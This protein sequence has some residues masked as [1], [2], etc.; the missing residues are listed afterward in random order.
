MEELILIDREANVLEAAIIEWDVPSLK[1]LLSDRNLLYSLGYSSAEVDHMHI[2]YFGIRISDPDQMTNFE[3]AVYRNDKRTILTYYNYM[4]KSISA[5][6]EFGYTETDLKNIRFV[7]IGNNKRFAAEVIDSYVIA[8]RL[9]IM[10]KNKN[11][12]AEK[13]FIKY[14][15]ET[16]EPLHKAEA[17]NSLVKIY[18]EEDYIPE[19]LKD[20]KRLSELYPE[21]LE[22]AQLN[23][24]FYIELLYRDNNNPNRYQEICKLGDYYEEQLKLCEERRS[25]ATLTPEEKEQLRKERNKYILEEKAK[26]LYAISLFKNHKNGWKYFFKNKLYEL[27][28]VSYMKDCLEAAGDMLKLCIDNNMKEGEMYYSDVLH[29]MAEKARG[30]RGN[31]D[32]AFLLYL[33]R[34]FGPEYGINTDGLVENYLN[35]DR[36]GNPFEYNGYGTY[37][38]ALA[39]EYTRINK[40]LEGFPYKAELD[41]LKREFYGYFVK[42]IELQLLGSQTA[43]ETIRYKINLINH[44][45]ETGEKKLLGDSK[46]NDLNNLPRYLFYFQDQDRSLYDKYNDILQ[47]DV[48]RAKQQNIDKNMLKNLKLSILPNQEELFAEDNDEVIEEVSFFLWKKIQHSFDDSKDQWLL[49]AKIYEYYSNKYKQLSINES[50]EDK[51]QEY[52]SLSTAYSNKLV[53]ALRIRAELVFV[54]DDWYDLYQYYFWQAKRASYN[55]RARWIKPAYELYLEIAYKI[56]NDSDQTGRHFNGLHDY[57]TDVKNN[58]FGICIRTEKRLAAQ[59]IEELARLYYKYHHYRYLRFAFEITKVSKDFALYQK[60]FLQALVQWEMVQLIR[61]IHYLLKIG[62]YDRAQEFY[63]NCVEHINNIPAVLGCTRELI[64]ELRA[65]GRPYNNNIFNL[66]INYP[67]ISNEYHVIESRNGNEMAMQLNIKALKLIIDYYT[68]TEELTGDLDCSPVYYSLYLQYKQLYSASCKDE[69][70]TDMK[71]TLTAAGEEKGYLPYLYKVVTLC[72]RYEQLNSYADTIVERMKIAPNLAARLEE[73]RLL[74]DSIKQSLNTA[75][76]KVF[77]ELCDL[78]L[79]YTRDSKEQTISDIKD[80]IT[81]YILNDK[82]EMTEELIK[83]LMSFDMIDKIWLKLYFEQKQQGQA[84]ILADYAR[85]FYPVNKVLYLLDNSND[86]ERNMFN[87]ELLKKCIY[88]GEGS[89]RLRQDSPY[90]MLVSDYLNNNSSSGFKGAELLHHLFKSMEKDRGPALYDVIDTINEASGYNNSHCILLFKQLYEE[91]ADYSYL[92]GLARQH[93]KAHNYADAE[94]C[95]GKLLEEVK[96]NTVLEKRYAYVKNHRHA[97]AILIKANNNEQIRMAE[98][99]DISARQ[100]CEVFAYLSDKYADEAT[101]VA[102][103]LADERERKLLDYI[104]HLISFEEQLSDMR[105]KRNKGAD[106]Y[107]ETQEKTLLE[108]LLQL[109]GTVYFELLLPNLYQRSNNNDFKYYLESLKDSNIQTI[110]RDANN[111][112]VLTFMGQ[113]IAYGQK[114]VFMDYERQAKNVDININSLDNIQETSLLQEI[115]NNHK[116]K[117]ANYSL[118]DLLLQLDRETY[119]PGKYRNMLLNVLS[120]R[121]GNPIEFERDRALQKRL[122]LAKA[123]LGYLMHIE[124][125]DR[126]REEAL[127]LLHEGLVCVENDK[128]YYKLILEKIRD[129]YLLILEG[130]AEKSLHEASKHF[131]IMMSDIKKITQILDNDNNDNNVFLKDML[132]V[133]SRL[134]IYAGT[135]RESNE[136]EILETVMVKLASIRTDSELIKNI[137]RQWSARLYSELI[138]RVDRSVIRDNKYFIDRKDSNV[139]LDD[140]YQQLLNNSKNVNVYGP[141]G[142]GVSSLLLQC[143]QEYSKEALQRGSLFLYADIRELS[144]YYDSNEKYGF[145]RRLAELIRQD[146]RK[147]SDIGDVLDTDLLEEAEQTDDLLNYFKVIKR[148]KKIESIILFMD[149]YDESDAEARKKADLLLYYLDMEGIRLVLGSESQIR[150]KSVNFK[151]VEL[152]GFSEKESK[153]YIHSRLQYNQHLLKADSYA[154]IYKLTGGIPALLAVAIEFILEDR[155]FKEAELSNYLINKARKLFISWDSHWREQLNREGNE[156]YRSYLGVTSGQIAEELK[157][158][159]DELEKIVQDNTSTIKD[160]TTSI[161][162]TKT[163]LKAMETK[164][165]FISKKLYAENNHVTGNINLEEYHKANKWTQ[166]REVNPEEYGTADDIWD[167]IKNDYDI[168]RYIKFGEALKQELFKLSEEERVSDYDYSVFALN[169]CLSFELLCHKMLKSFLMEKIPDYQTDGIKPD[170]PTLKDSKADTKYTLGQYAR[171]VKFFSGRYFKTLKRAGIRTEQLVDDMFAAAKI[172]NDVAHANVTFKEEQFHQLIYLLF[173]DK[174]SR[175]KKTPIFEGICR[176]VNLNY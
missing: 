74:L 87:S 102:E 97:I 3:S 132:F 175:G 157:N 90:L 155:S 154:R 19:R 101:K 141:Q 125:Y 80:F 72:Y 21:M 8:N 17:I 117:Q 92:T 151:T 44:S 150:V 73:Y 135:G 95:Y 15:K 5:M 156:A 122:Q 153:A 34:Q 12:M 76:D 2:M 43:C 120:F 114:L 158:K 27:T 56:H 29:I 22:Y 24:S 137:I 88:Y 176:I 33:N 160:H 91:T 162:E 104:Y 169:Y 126:N 163:Q 71:E 143:C 82:Y 161:I 59:Y 31:A 171:F 11:R 65:T 45:I 103:L 109:K 144:S 7:H 86:A 98:Q 60:C 69:Y 159:V 164:F 149:H 64:D 13:Y 61:N 25:D 23:R 165:N 30:K 121:P 79:N 4:E 131:A 146:I 133:I 134:Q 112:P 68:G 78:T 67:N 46:K 168:Y 152:A 170:I 47:N 28:N 123:E 84:L 110:L 51:K 96:E 130:L 148:E 113:R 39:E 41:C 66:L 26:Y 81:K 93:A 10:Q 32:Y 75:Q 38:Y 36:E 174:N 111:K 99:E 70:L 166:Q 172:R 145:G 119:N 138:I 115:I 106:A 83:Y 40:S 108:K 140:I 1:K 136:V 16:A 52:I 53:N 37:L 18:K 77:E 94:A 107:E 35:A 54:Y 9:H 105:S 147:V 14:L 100:I 129:R 6:E 49:L 62:E 127:M 128:A 20:F 167:V 173:G 139:T 85:G 89:D 63:D 142:V 48:K 55:E 42:N 124:S 118:N 58:L 116:Q 57:F 50:A